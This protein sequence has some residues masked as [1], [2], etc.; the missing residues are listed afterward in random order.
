MNKV[1]FYCEIIQCK[2]IILH[3]NN[4]I[5]IRNTIND[6]KFNLTIKVRKSPNDISPNDFL[7]L[8][9]PHPYYYFLE[10]RSKK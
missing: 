1:I 5:Y 3:E 2:K 7:S 10:I 4:N 8:Y 6:D 9:Y